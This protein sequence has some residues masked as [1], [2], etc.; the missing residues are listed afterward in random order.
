MIKNSTKIFEIYMIEPQYMVHY[1]MRKKYFALIHFFCQ[2]TTSIKLKKKKKSNLKCKGGVCTGENI[3]I[4]NE[5]IFCCF[6]F[7]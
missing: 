2:V 7:L 4:Q 5:L 3:A 6:L 1:S